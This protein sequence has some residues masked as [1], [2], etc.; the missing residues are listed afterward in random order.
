M[1]NSEGLEYLTRYYTI[2]VGVMYDIYVQGKIKLRM[3][4][5]YN[6][7]LHFTRA[8]PKISFKFFC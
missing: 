2:S 3:Q 6:T 1:Q 8:F 4:F 5:F 7:I